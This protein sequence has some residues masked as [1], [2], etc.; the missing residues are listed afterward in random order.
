[1][2][3]VVDLELKEFA[4]NLFSATCRNL[5]RVSLEFH[6]PSRLDRFLV[7]VTGVFAAM[8]SFSVFSAVLS[9]FGL[10]R[11]LTRTFRWRTL[12]EVGCFCLLICWLLFSSLSSLESSITL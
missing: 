3:E 12:T 6:C 5:E 1:V 2:T 8:L 7:V 9:C 4:L 10:F 11:C